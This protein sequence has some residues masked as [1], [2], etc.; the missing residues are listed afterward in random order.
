MTDFDF[1][2]ITIL[3][4]IVQAH[5]VVDFYELSRESAEALLDEAEWIKAWELAEG[6]Y[7]RD[8]EGWLL[9]ELRW[10]KTKA[11][12]EGHPAFQ[13]AERGWLAMRCV[14]RNLDGVTEFA[15]LTPIM[16]RRYALFA[17][18]VLGTDIDFEAESGTV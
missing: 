15:Q 6:R 4:N 10:E 1:N 12:V 3:R 5:R 7:K 11:L 2:D 9:A 14:T 8:V 17:A 13:A 16:Q 18:A